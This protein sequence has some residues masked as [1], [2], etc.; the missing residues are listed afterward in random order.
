[1]HFSINYSVKNIKITVLIKAKAIFSIANNTLTLVSNLKKKTLVFKRN[2]KYNMLNIQ[3]IV[4]I[5]LLT[6][7]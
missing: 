4:L 5:I 2:I 3:V 7:S 6:D 1:M